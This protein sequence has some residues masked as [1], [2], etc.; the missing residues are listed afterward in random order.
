MARTDKRG[1]KDRP[2][3]VFKGFI[4]GPSRDAEDELPS[5]DELKPLKPN[6]IQI[7]KMRRSEPE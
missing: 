2:N 1:R 5:P 3:I 6:K 4:S 7:G